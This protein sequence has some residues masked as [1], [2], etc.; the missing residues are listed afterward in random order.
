V[1]A[2]DAKETGAHFTEDGVL[3]PR[4]AD[5]SAPLLERWEKIHGSLQLLPE[6]VTFDYA[7][8]PWPWTWRPDIAALFLAQLD[9]LLYLTIP[10]IQQ[11][12]WTDAPDGKAYL[13]EEACRP[14]IK[15]AIETAKLIVSEPVGNVPKL[16][17]GPYLYDTRSAPPNARPT[18]IIIG[19]FIYPP[20]LH[21]F[22]RIADRDQLA[23]RHTRW[24]SAHENAS[25][26]REHMPGEVGFARLPGV[27]L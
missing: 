10:R 17:P 27:T 22:K 9:D 6:P 2:K 3:A 13:F 7:R 19:P 24:W 25:I 16:G 5:V 8:A 21:S 23:E 4:A 18:T 14:E 20:G 1:A 12:A 11:L 26:G 15:K